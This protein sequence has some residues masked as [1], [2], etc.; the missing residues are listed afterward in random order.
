MVN[1]L[2]LAS[3]VGVV[4]TAV[5]IFFL[6]FITPPPPYSGSSTYTLFNFIFTVSKGVIPALIL[7]CI[8]TGF[9]SGIIVK[10]SLQGFVAGFVGVFLGAAPLINHFAT[11]CSFGDFSTIVFP[12]PT[13]CIYLGVIYSIRGIYTL[14]SSTNGALLL[15]ALLA[16]LGLFSGL[17]GGLIKVAWDK[18]IRSKEVKFDK[19]ADKN[20]K[21]PKDR[22][23][24]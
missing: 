17:V 19:E 14:S 15:S 20:H 9:T 6:T 3:I 13:G 7:I 1:R 4:T 22:A 21:S 2:I 23:T 18:N 12:L 24:Q 5:L 8:F 11:T 10:S 16:L